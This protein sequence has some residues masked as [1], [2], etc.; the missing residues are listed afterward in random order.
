MTKKQKLRNKADR[1][2][3]NYIK[4]KYKTCFICGKRQIVGHHFI[5]KSNS[6][7]LR[8]SEENIIPLC[9]FCHCL[10]HSQPALI[11]AKIVLKKGK[12]WFKKLQQQKRKQVKTNLTFYQEVIKRYDK[13]DVS[14]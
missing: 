1:V 7:A 10:I 3:Q 2:F 14:K 4:G 6:S 5:Q 12:D 8:Y 13:E 11:T 9:N